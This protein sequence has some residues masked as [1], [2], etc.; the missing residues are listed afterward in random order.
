MTGTLTRP[1]AEQEDQT[2]APATPEEQKETP[3]A[4]RSRTR[5][6]KPQPAVET[7]SYVLPPDLSGVIKPADI[8]QKGEGKY[9]ADYVNWCRVA[10]FLRAH[11]PGWEFHLRKAEDGGYVWQAPNGTAYVIAYFVG[12]DGHESPELP[13][14]IMDN[15]NAPVMFKMVDA[16]DVTD[17]HRRALCTAAAFVFSLAWQ[18]WAK[19]AVEDPHQAEDRPR[20]AAPA[21]ARQGSVPAPARPPGPPARPAAARAAAPTR[22]AAPAAPAPAP[23]AA[24]PAAPAAPQAGVE[25]AAESLAAATGGE[26]IDDPAIAE[27]FIPLPDEYPAEF[28]QGEA[29][30]ALYRKAQGVRLSLVGWSTLDRSMQGLDPAKAMKVIGSRALDRVDL[31]ANL[32]Q[33]LN[34]RGERV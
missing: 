9:K 20:A 1:P 3:A 30:V 8:D 15:R 26:V 29:L 10:N 22:A 31:V 4:T 34:S 25:Q 17:T 14:A 32:N 23:A 33:G 12:P 24:A 21:P 19:E 7:F 11:A 16:R 28:P 2:T 6:A 18:L 27:D 5:A 13:Q